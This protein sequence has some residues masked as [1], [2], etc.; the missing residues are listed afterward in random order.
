MATTVS[1]YDPELTQEEIG[2]SR[3]QALAAAL[4]QQA[5]TP[6]G[7]T[8]MVS[9]RAIKRS[10]ME[11]LAKMFQAYQAAK[12]G[13]ENDR[14]AQ[15]L[16]VRDQELTNKKIAEIIKLY[17]GTPGTPDTPAI[18]EVSQTNQS[19]DMFEPKAEIKGVAAVPGNPLVAALKAVA[20]KRTAAIGGPMLTAAMKMEE[21][22]N[23]PMVVGRSLV[24]PAGKHLASDSTWVEEREQERQREIA[25]QA[26][27]QAFRDQQAR[28][29]AEEIK[30]R[31]KQ[32]A[33][34]RENQI[35]VAASMRPPAAVQPL[36][37]VMTPD[38]ERL[39]E[40]KDA[41]GA[42]P[43][44]IGSKSAAKME[45]RDNVDKS[46]IALKEAIS[47]LKTGG[48]MGS[49]D[50]NPLSNAAAYI[51][52]SGPGQTYGSVFR[53]KNQSARNE[54]LQARPLL[55]TSI[56]NAT[57]MSAKQMD[58]NVELKLWLATAT[59]PEK[60]YE[61]NMKALNNIAERF[62]SGAID[63]GRDTGVKKIGTAKSVMDKADEILGRK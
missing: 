25:K 35:R 13:G 62:G 42:V 43:G 40:R 36:V 1:P 14:T 9:G 31:D 24:T 41:I 38:G 12:I 54:M 50:N 8:E 28:Q 49:T 18:T 22:K 44:G 32:S 15:E 17:Q 19:Q 57:G 63:K 51:S 52:S 37:A 11:G 47:T 58:S 5:S 55:L 39:V 10:P 48:G 34:E 6:L 21:E 4:Q 7:P 23:K 20:D 26:S 2:L 45:G 56:M 27:D 59:D 53:T 33:L 61:E 3:R 29:H 30:Q 16:A 60:G 46:V